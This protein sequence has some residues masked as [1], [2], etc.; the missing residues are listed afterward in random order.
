MD[1]NNYNWHELI[2]VTSNNL[3]NIS[4]IWS[5]LESIKIYERECCDISPVIIF[6]VKIGYSN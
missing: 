4:H 6:D 1:Q 3:L 2:C 5:N